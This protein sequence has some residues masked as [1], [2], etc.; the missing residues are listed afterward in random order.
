M[1]RTRRRHPRS[2]P[3]RLGVGLL[4]AGMM[5]FQWIG[6]AG[7]AISLV[8]PFGRLVCGPR[9][10]VTFCSGGLNHRVPSFDGVPLDADLTLPARGRPPYPLIVLLHGL[11]G[12]K[13]ETESTT[14]DGAIDN[15]TFVSH[16]WAVLSYSARGFGD[17]CGTPAARR[18]A[19]AC[20]RGWSHL[21]DQRYEVRDTQYLAGLLVDEGYVLPD[22]AVAG[23]SYGGAQ[24]LEL[25][26]LKNRVELPDGRFITFRSPRRHVPMAVAAVYAAWPWDD[27]ASA[28]QPNGTSP[29]VG[30]Q[31]A[32]DRTPP[33]ILKQAWATILAQAEASGYQ[34]PPV[35]ARRSALAEWQG[36]ASAN[37]ASSPTL[38][39]ALEDLQRFHSAV[40]IPTPAG[41]PAPTVIQSGFTDSLFPVTEALRFADQARRSGSR[42]P[43][44]L[45]FDDVGHSWAQNK[46]ADV[47]FNNATAIAFLD[48]VVQHRA[49]PTGVMVRAQRCPLSAPSGSTERARSWAALQR[50][51]VTLKGSA[52]Q[53]VTSAGGDPAVAAALDATSQPLCD[54]LSAAPE[55]G[56]ATYEVKVG[57]GGL[58]VLGG[59]TVTAKLTIT[60]TNPE[61]IGRLWDVAPGRTT[62]Q[63]I[64]MGA[65]APRMIPRPGVGATSE[66]VRFEL[67]PND[68]VV[69]PGHRIELELV[70]S[71]APFYRPSATPFSITVTDL[72]A[73]VPLGA[74]L[75]SM[76]RA[77][78]VHE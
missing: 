38:I 56:T 53:V 10:G 54:P 61:L 68:V 46:P 24:A 32:L 9:F 71:T 14:D 39:R 72:R 12:N 2:L 41:G 25:A 55:P 49:P 16:G 22:I 62:R 29:E 45:I 5:S 35:V 60:G 51:S 17:S 57:P 37:N 26:M 8:R 58:H 28:L 13:L 65:F 34:P 70:G 3:R 7:G 47:A 1:P 27:Y 74:Q 15:L 76:R 31:A 23:V 44:L 48:A 75:Q 69:A 64:E 18:T 20:A 73:R 77:D 66:R 59:V 21:A 40:G 78:N 11:G 42:S 36:S 43:L 52:A 50:S 4:V 6:P 63:I 67:P 19:P 33:G 30:N